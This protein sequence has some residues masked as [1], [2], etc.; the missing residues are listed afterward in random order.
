MMHG[1]YNIKKLNVFQ[2]SESS[3]VKVYV[4]VWFLMKGKYANLYIRQT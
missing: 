4:T 1:A 3:A 2:C